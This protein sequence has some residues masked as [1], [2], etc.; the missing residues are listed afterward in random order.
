[1]QHTNRHRAA[2]WPG[3]QTAAPGR[4]LGFSLEAGLALNHLPRGRFRVM[5]QPCSRAAVLRPSSETLTLNPPQTFASRIMKRPINLAVALA[6]LACA[7]FHLQAQTTAFTYQGRLKD[8]GGA[9]TGIYDL[10]FMICDSGGGPAVVA[11]PLT[12]SPTSVTNG[13]FAVTLDFGS[14]IFTGADRW[15][16]IALRTNGGHDFTT[17]LPRQALTPAPYAVYAANAGSAARAATAASAGS[18]SASNIAGTLATAQLPASV[19]TNGAAGVNL[20]G[21]FSG[22]FGGLTNFNMSI[23]SFGSGVNRLRFPAS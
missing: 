23:A 7:A 6:S 21:A 17:L 5:G 3:R 11:G 13:L 19:L 8:G 4:A 2:H 9:V 1:M 12:N 16:E 20:S 18:V 15:L 22:G 10:R 14:G